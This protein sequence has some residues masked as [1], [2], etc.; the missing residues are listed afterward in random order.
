MTFNEMVAVIQDH[1]GISGGETTVTEQ[2][3]NAGKDRYVN[4]AKWPHLESSEVQA[5]ASGVRVFSAPDACESIVGIEDASGSRITKVERDSWDELFRS[6]TSTATAPTH[7]SEQ[8][9]DPNAIHQFQVWPNP[10][11]LSTGKI[12]YLVRVPDLT[13]TDGTYDHIP[14]AHHFAIIKAAETKFY[15]RQGQNSK[16]ALAEQQF[17]VIIQQLAGDLAMPVLDDGSE[18]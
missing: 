9:T 4:A 8:G 6:D 17:Q 2:A 7:Y 1:L 3:V 14:E 12:R 11:A 5:F 10:S 15:Q 13:S 18:K 16:S